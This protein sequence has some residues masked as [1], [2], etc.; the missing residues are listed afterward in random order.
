MDEVLSLEMLPSDLK[1]VIH[2]LT[3]NSK[4]NHI[5]FYRAET[6]YGFMTLVIEKFFIGEKKTEEG[7]LSLVRKRNE[8][9]REEKILTPVVYEQNIVE[10]NEK[11]FI[12]LTL[13]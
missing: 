8:L 1:T 6:T 9:I 12:S 2:K 7:L 13:T 11:H 5:A 10:V 4:Y 3:L